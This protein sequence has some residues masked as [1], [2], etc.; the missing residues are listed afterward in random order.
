MVNLS[1]YSIFLQDLREIPT[2]YN[3]F[4]IAI[5]T[6]NNECSAA[7]QHPFCKRV[8]G[9]PAARLSLGFSKGLAGKTK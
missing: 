2:A 3:I 6:I 8:E 1:T 5:D 7:G 4:S 9:M